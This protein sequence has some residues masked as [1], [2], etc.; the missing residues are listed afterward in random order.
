MLLYE[1]KIKI[2][3]ISVKRS[4][5]LNNLTYQQIRN[6]IDEQASERWRQELLKKQC[7]RQNCNATNNTN[8]KFVKCS[9]CFVSVYCSR[10]CANKFTMDNI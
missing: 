10:K 1:S 4:S 5:L 7:L 9:K 6:M 2:F 3:K 8:A